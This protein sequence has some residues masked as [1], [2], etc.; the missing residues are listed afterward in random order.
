M[1]AALD[2]GGMVEDEYNA[3]HE[4]SELERPL[5]STEAM[6]LYLNDLKGISRLNNAQEYSLWCKLDAGREAASQ[7]IAV[8]KN[9]NGTPVSQ[10]IG[11][12]IHRL[13]NKIRAGADA[14]QQLIESTMPLVL[15]YAKK[16]AGR[17]PILDLIQDG[18]IALMKAAEN[19]EYRDSCSFASFAGRYM[20][21]EMWETR[22]KIKAVRVPQAMSQAIR[23]VD[24]FSDCFQREC[25]HFPAPE[26]IATE[27]KIPVDVISEIWEAKNTSDDTYS[28]DMPVG[29]EE[30]ACTLEDVLPDTVGQ[31]PEEAVTQTMLH[32]KVMEILNTLDPI[33]EK[34]IKLRF[35]FEDGY[36]RPVDD[37]CQQCDTDRENV[38]RAEIM[39]LRKLRHPSRSRQLAGFLYD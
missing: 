23:L 15:F 27:M 11:M 19:Y 25:G 10:D 37:V 1:D 7:L 30:E 6:T 13:K 34:V 29:T 12:E 5:V 8:E 3:D 4:L 39:A 16:Y 2:Y 33:E 24:Q 26:E 32:E 35:G 9:L 28:L 17:T 38:I 14:Q 31:T 36:P 21:H 22:K 20:M 18:N